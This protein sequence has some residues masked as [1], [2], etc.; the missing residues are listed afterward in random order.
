L[1]STQHVTFTAG[2]NFQFYGSL[3]GTSTNITL[4]NNAKIYGSMLG[5]SVTTGSGAAVHFDQAMSNRAVCNPG[6]N[7]TILR[8]TWREVIP[9]T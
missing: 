5:R 6:G 3:Y 4:G 1:P 7:F 9:S 8:G 2:D